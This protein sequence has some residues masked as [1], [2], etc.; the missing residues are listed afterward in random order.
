MR[1]YEINED[2]FNAIDTEE[3]AYF[4]GFLFAD[5]YINEKSKVVVLQLA[6][7]DKEILEKLNKVI[8]SNR[9]L[10]YISME[11]NRKKGIKVQDA[12]RLNINCRK[13]YDNIVNYGCLPRKTFTL[14]F[15]T[16]DVIPYYLI[17]HFVRG[18]FD[19]DGSLVGYF[20][21]RGN[22]KHFQCDV[23]I[24]STLEFINQLSVLTS[25]ELSI[26][27]NV[28]KRFKDG[29]NNY[30]YQLSGN[31]NVIKFLEW[32][33]KDANIYLDR[34]FQTFKRVVNTINNGKMHKSKTHI[35]NSIF[36]SK[37]II[38]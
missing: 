17:R 35:H 6:E 12:F 29:K 38:H 19:G 21:S 26:S 16:N 27:T 5:G 2:T 1:K 32:I 23:K 8:K 15:P 18:Y 4:L 36:L 20:P 31:L 25:D 34:K 24:V 3:K 9:P 14:K 33:Y 7:K 11:C 22:G 28:T 37:L 30:N 13:I 10:Q